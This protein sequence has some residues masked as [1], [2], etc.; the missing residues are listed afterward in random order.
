MNRDFDTT[1]ALEIFSYNL[2]V[3]YNFYIVVLLER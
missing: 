2:M 1:I 3:I